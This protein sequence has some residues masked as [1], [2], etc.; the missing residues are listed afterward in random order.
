MA[1]VSLAIGVV[2]TLGFLG[3]A[4]ALGLSARPGADVPVHDVPLVA[5]S[6]LA[7]GSGFL[8]AFS[9]SASALRGDRTSGVRHLF[10][11]RT[12]S[13][14]GYLTARVGGLAVVLAMVTAGGSL[15]VGVGS[16]LLASTGAEILRTLQTTVASTVYGLVFALLLAPLALAALGARTRVGGYGALLL[17]VIVPE[18]VV[19]LVGDAIPSAVAEICSVPS[20]L[21]A[22]R[23]SLAPTAASGTIDLL[24]CLRAT[25]AI[26]VMALV[27]F[28]IVRRDVILLEYE[29]EVT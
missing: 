2:T 16:L 6:A 25:V 8:L 23:S 14:R 13:M 9:A 1:F 21:A 27:A 18:V 11:T 17:I 19:S 22:F 26:A 10:V 24:R 29:R 3:V 20:A 12:T 7:W 5:S 28:A 15:L 4:L